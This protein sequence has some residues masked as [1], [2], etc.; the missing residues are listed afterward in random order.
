MTG[1][2]PRLGP[3]LMVALLVAACTT[4]GARQDATPT[5]PPSV[6]TI[7][8]ATAPATPPSGSAA[9]T[10]P[11][12][13]TP[14]ASLPTPD[15][16]EPTPIVEPGEP[17]QPLHDLVTGDGTFDLADLAG[18]QVLLFFGYTH[19]P[20]V[21]PMTIGELVLVLRERPETRVV[22]VTVDP[23]RDTQESLAEWTRYLPDGIVALT[24]SP[25]AI[26]AAADAYGVRY[27]RVDSGSAAGYAMSHT[28]FVYLIDA[29][30]RLRVTFPFGTG[31]ATI[32][33]G[34]DGASTSSEERGT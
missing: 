11:G 22:F 8:S 19:C 28:A 14:R 20:D 1:W 25:S 31:W 15:P 16:A 3:G 23:E 10:V 13:P 4:G 12:A 5:P 34:L 9:S 6:P 26:R 21:C 27:A 30:G 2:V 32:V 29:D 24:G 17:A 18:N 7:V 33:R